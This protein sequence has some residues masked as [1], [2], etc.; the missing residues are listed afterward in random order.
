[1]KVLLQ[2]ADKQ[3]G[4]RCVLTIQLDGS[5]EYQLCDGFVDSGDLK[6][7]CTCVGI[8]HL[9]SL[10]RI[11]IH[12]S[13]GVLNDAPVMANHSLRVAERGQSLIS[14]TGVGET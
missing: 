7:R 6:Q 3:L 14:R 10:N 13:D 1:L 2:E 4:D 11:E 8:D 9:G 5:A 12:L